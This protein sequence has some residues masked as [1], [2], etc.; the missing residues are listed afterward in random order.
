MDIIYT[1]YFNKRKPSCKY[2][3]I[4][5]FT[6]NREIT[7]IY[8]KPNALQ[9][10]SSKQR[11]LLSNKGPNVVNMDRNWCPELIT[12]FLLM[13]KYQVNN[14]NHWKYY[15][16][17]LLELIVYTTIFMSII[18]LNKMKNLGPRWPV[19]WPLWPHILF[20][21]ILIFLWVHDEALMD[22][23]NCHAS[24]LKIWN[25]DLYCFPMING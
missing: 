2:K 8:L 23:L 9:Q 5:S 11:N 12:E 4:I 16:C 20:W 3:I 14:V 18:S 17:R 21:P 13:V 22:V 1:S 15:N 24:Y 19:M 25:R 7:G 6:E 10:T